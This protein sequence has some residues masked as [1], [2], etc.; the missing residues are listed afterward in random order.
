M[1]ADLVDFRDS[2]ARFPSRTYAAGEVI[3]RE[4]DAADFACQVI[5]G[6][7]GISVKIGKAFRTIARL[8][9]NEPFGELAIL[10]DKPRIA[11]AT[12]L[13]KSTIRIIRQQELSDELEKMSPWVGGIISAL[14]HRFVE[15]GQH[16][17]KLEETIDQL[18]EQARLAEQ[19][20]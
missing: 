10:T 3:F 17:R 15:Q 7:V 13:E 20:K 6:C 12:A 1:I 11:T 16:I 2:G 5:T 19:K 4:G 18:K 9:G 8:Q 14:S